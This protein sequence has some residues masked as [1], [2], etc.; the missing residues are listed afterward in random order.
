MTINGIELTEEQKEYL[1]SEMKDP[2]WGAG[3]WGNKVAR[4]LLEIIRSKPSPSVSQ[5]MCGKADTT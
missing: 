2:D 1:T 4:E 5:C 3:S